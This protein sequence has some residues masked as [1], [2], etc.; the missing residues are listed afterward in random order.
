MKTKLAAHPIKEYWGRWDNKTHLLRFH[1]AHQRGLKVMDAAWV[2]ELFS[3]QISHEPSAWG[4]ITHLWVRRHDSQALTWKVMQR[5]KNE[6]VGEE[7]IGVEVYPAASEVVDQANMYHLW[8]LPEGFAL[9]FTLK[10]QNSEEKK[11]QS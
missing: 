1:P 11:C 2:N 7:R 4:E 10:G 3:V 8:I 9:P 6:L 5:I